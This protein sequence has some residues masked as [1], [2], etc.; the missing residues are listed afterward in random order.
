MAMA[1]YGRIGRNVPRFR[2]VILNWERFSPQ[3]KFSNI[4]RHF[5]CLVVTILRGT[6]SF[7]QIESREAA[8][9]LRMNLVGYFPTM[10]NY[11]VLTVSS[12]K[13]EK[14]WYGERI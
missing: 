10:Q 3:G 2:L 13:V 14:P 4:W 8:K 6:T 9:H 11:L 1:G 12:S 7:Q 5:F